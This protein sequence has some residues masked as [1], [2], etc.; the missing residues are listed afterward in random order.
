MTENTR[1]DLTVKAEIELYYDVYVPDGLA[2]P[3]PLLIAVHGYG[4][5]KRYMMREA[6]LVTG[7]QYVIAA[8]E[9]PHPHYRPT[10]DGGY[11]IGYGWLSE[12]RP[13]PHIRLHH[14]FVNEVI[15]RLVREGLA[16]AGRVFM[17][18]FSQAC[19]LDLRFAFTYPDRLAGIAGVC[20]G[21]P[22]DL[23]TN[24]IYKPFAAQ[25]IYLYGDDDEFY[26]NDQFAAFD[27]KLRSLLPNYVSKQFKAKHEI[28]E[29]MRGEIRR[30]LDISR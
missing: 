11:A 30:F 25:T 2:K 29:E 21:I 18:G 15:D 12:R 1:T 23:D 14:D 26:T 6:K 28:T 19:A 9:A 20:G 16:D 24:P 4:A 22:G 8:I 17:Y 5:H 13:E 27:A 3:A 7:G 10:K